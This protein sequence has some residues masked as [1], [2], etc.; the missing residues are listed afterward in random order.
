MTR[1]PLFTYK[2]GLAVPVVGMEAEFAVVIDG[3]EVDP[4]D[5]WSRPSDFVDEPLLR[6]STKSSQLPTGGAVY[7]DKGVIEVVTP[8][9]ELGPS[10]AARVVRNLWE[11]IGFVRDHLDNWEK[12]EEKRV[13]LR[14]F[15]CHYNISFELTSAD[16][17]RN[18]TIQKLA[19]LLARLLTVPII[20]LGANRRSTGV[21]IRPRRNRIEMTMDFTPDPGLMAASAAIAIAIAREVISWPSYL[22]AEL[23]DKKVSY[24]GDVDPGRHT[25]RKG[26]LT[27]DYHFARSPFT[28]DVDAPLLKNQ[29]GEE[30]SLREMALETVLFFEESIREYADPFTVALIFSVLRGEVPSLLE[31][32]DRPASYDDIGRA[33]RWGS[34]LPDLQ[35]YASTVTE[36]DHGALEEHLSWRNDERT[37]YLT[38]VPTTLAEAEDRR[39]MVGGHPNP[40]R[41]ATDPRGDLTPPWAFD[42]DRRR[43]GNTG[44]RR[45][46]ERRAPEPLTGST[47][48]RSPYE[49]IFMK[50]GSR[51]PLQLG[52]E[53]LD[54]IGVKGWYH[55]VFKRRSDG[56]TEVVSIDQLLEN[57]PRWQ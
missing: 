46:T 18:Q 8:G 45:R 4:E 40:S 1:A 5:I 56:A 20:M 42:S 41:R 12:R 2:S 6:R 25:T 11:H 15:S 54:P 23:D 17:N 49:K 34:V 29:R 3:E 33:V 13:Q 10:C 37:R 14:A 52:D 51:T 38:E 36:D 39:T 30:Q 19:V 24:P 55:G 35:N 53:V 26:W 16:R 22:V 31:L 43:V 44:G 28:S 57:L 50:L 47:L 27:K 9:I 48:T 32:P 21:G 7:F